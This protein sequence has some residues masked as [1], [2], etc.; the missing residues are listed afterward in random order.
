MRLEKVQI[1]NFRS[2]QS[3]DLELTPSCRI[4]VGINE[5]G[6][7]NILRAISSLGDFTPSKSDDVRE[8]APGEG[9]IEESFVRFCFALEK[10]EVEKLIGIVSNSIFAT[11]LTRG[12]IATFKGKPLS[13]NAFVQSRSTGLYEAD[14]LNEEKNSKYWTIGSEFAL[15]EGWSRPSKASPDDHYVTR[16]DGT[17]VRLK[18]LRL[19]RAADCPQAVEWLEP[20]DIGDLESLVGGAL[21]S[22][23]KANLPEV[24]FWQYTEQ[25]LLPGSINLDGFIAD[26]TSCLPLMNM[27]ALADI[28]D[29]PEAVA[30]A[31]A[32]S[33]N[34]LHNFFSNIASKTTAH[35]RSVWKE[36]KSIEFE[37]VPD[38]AELIAGV[39]E[40]NRFDFAKRSDGFKRFVSFLL[41]ISAKVKSGDLSDTVLL[42]DEPDIS[43][44][45]SGAR[46]LRDELIEI[47]KTN[48]VVYSTHSIF[49]IDRENVGRHIIVTKQHE[50]TRLS[51]ANESNVVDEEVL[52][53]AVGYSI[54]E[55]LRKKNLVFEGWR[56]KHLFQ[57]AITRMPKS[58]VSAARILAEVGVCHA[59]GVKDIRNITPMMELANRYCLIISDGDGPARE[60]QRDHVESRG[61]G[62]WKRYDEVLDA[63]Q[64]IGIVTSEDFLEIAA[65]KPGLQDARDRLGI[66]DFD[67]QKWGGPQ[68]SLYAIGEWLRAGNVGKDIRE[69]EI[70]RIKKAVWDELSARDIREL[71]YT[72][73]VKLAADVKGM[74]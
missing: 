48:T 65:F 47:S 14:L 29:I 25:N 11:N 62:L 41:L 12:A 10:E 51:E 36:H 34:T 59:K 68:G 72:Y 45:P 58:A 23:I 1:K 46:F 19:L 15:A 74:K 63:E 6:K 64:A 13:L 55:S 52:F 26:P 16:R 67:D 37:L 3:V 73:L 7:S 71:Y 39:R 20:A 30:K 31:R 4:L 69:K 33:R 27:F 24:L 5:S 66:T 9:P 22:Q 43:L 17:K 53:N 57:V 38:G 21:A 32:G 40:K 54:F 2:I 8:P 28:D 42:I 50:K 70:Q 60:R 44:H 56:D 61:Y 35:F 49:M 18:N